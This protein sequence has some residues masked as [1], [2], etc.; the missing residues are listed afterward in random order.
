MFL[1]SFVG[2][3]SFNRRRINNEAINLSIMIKSNKIRSK[4]RDTTSY[5]H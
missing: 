1:E 4:L 2:N 3:F 5:D